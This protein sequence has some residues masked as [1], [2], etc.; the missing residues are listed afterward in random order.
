MKTA[1][2]KEKAGLSP[3][4]YPYRG[5]STSTLLTFRPDNSLLHNGQ[6]KTCPRDDWLVPRAQT[7]PSSS[8]LC[9]SLWAWSH[10]LLFYIIF[11]YESRMCPE[12]APGW[13]SPNHKSQREENTWFL[14]QYL[15]IPGKGSP[16]L[17]WL[18]YMWTPNLDQPLCSGDGRCKLAGFTRTV[19]L[20]RRWRNSTREG[21]AVPPRW[22]QD[23]G[24]ICPLLLE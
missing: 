12:V 14:S 9:I 5:F 6:R 18:G 15:K 20:K 1:A 4:H 24:N 22:M 21:S 8:V 23:R 11:L 10:F 2:G 13:V 19:W 17:A 3:F 16:S 7:R